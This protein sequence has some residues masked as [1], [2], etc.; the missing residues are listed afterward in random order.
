MKQ[1]VNLGK[2]WKECEILGDFDTQTKG[3]KVFLGGINKPTYQ[4]KKRCYK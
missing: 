4:K 3:S 1:L 2:V